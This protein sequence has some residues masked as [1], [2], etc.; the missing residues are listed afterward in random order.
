M[1]LDKYEQAIYDL[2]KTYIYETVSDNLNDYI[3][4]HIIGLIDLL[5][6]TIKGV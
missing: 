6:A 2:L 1:E 5:I 3:C 4:N